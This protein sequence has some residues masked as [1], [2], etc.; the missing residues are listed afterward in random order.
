MKKYFLSFIFLVLTLLSATANEVRILFSGSTLG[1]S[2]KFID[3]NGENQGGY[4]ARKTLI[5]DL[6]ENGE[7]NIVLVDM[8]SLAYEFIIF[9]NRVGE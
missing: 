5:D 9:S 6:R 1:H 7:N 8:L 2:L 3:D 4:P